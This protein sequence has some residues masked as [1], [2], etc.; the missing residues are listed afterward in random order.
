MELCAATVEDIFPPDQKYDGPLPRSDREALLQLAKGLQHIHEQGFIHRDIKPGN[1]LIS[2]PLTDGT[3][4]LK[5][6]DFGLSK[7]LCNGTYTVTTGGT[8]GWIAPEIVEELKRERMERERGSAKSDI[9]S[10]GWVFLCYL[11]R[12][13]GFPMDGQARGY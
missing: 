9:W 1:V 4:L 5:W 13:G 3:V 12:V 6:A 7:P 10:A 11:T 8:I 2:L